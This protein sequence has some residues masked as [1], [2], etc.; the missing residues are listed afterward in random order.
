[1][2]HE[3]AFVA[4]GCLEAPQRDGFIALVLPAVEAFSIL[5]DLELNDEEREDAVLD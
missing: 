4:I 5:I 3:L 1:M 2:P